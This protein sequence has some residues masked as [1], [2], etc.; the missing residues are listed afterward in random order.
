MQGPLT[1]YQALLDRAQSEPDRTYL[2]Q[3]FDGEVIRWTFREAADD[4][5]RIASALLA[6]GLQ[7][8]DKV[9]LL[10][11]NSAEWFLSDYAIMM[12]GLVAERSR[13]SDRSS[14]RVARRSSGSPGSPRA[15]RCW[16]FIG[17]SGQGA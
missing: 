14:R 2:N 4:A 10:G 13:R 17:A 5:S 7:R 1:A 15:R 12:A 9:A 6:L 8:G 16:V 11:K 3:P